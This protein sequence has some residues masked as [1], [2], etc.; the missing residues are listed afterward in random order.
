[1]DTAKR[2]PVPNNRMYGAAGFAKKCIDA[3]AVPMLT[4]GGIVQHFLIEHVN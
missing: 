3:G 2:Y 1:M 4:F